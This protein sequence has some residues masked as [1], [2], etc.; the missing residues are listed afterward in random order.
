MTESLPLPTVS[1]NIATLQHHEKN[2]LLKDYLDTINYIFTYYFETENGSY[3]FYDVENDSFKFKSSDDFKREVIVKLEKETDIYK[4]V[5]KN[6]KIFSVV[7]RIG[8]PRIYK[9]NDKYYLNESGSFLH[10][11]YKKYEDY[12]E[13]IKRKVNKIFEMIRDISCN[14]DEKV[15]KALL[16]W[17]AQIARGR[18]TECFITCICNVQGIGKSTL[19]EFFMNWVFGMK[20]CLLYPKKEAI[21]SNF[22][23]IF[24]GKLLILLEDLPEMSDNEYRTFSSTMKTLVT[25]K[26]S[27]YRDVFEKPIQAENISNFV[28][29]SNYPLKDTGRRI[30]S[31]DVS[32]KKRLDFTYFQKLRAECFN[33]KVGEAVFSYLLTKISDEECDTF[34]GQRDFPET[35]N[36]RTSIA[37]SLSSAHKYIKFNYVLRKRGISIIKRIDL[38]E[39]YKSFCRTKSLN[40]CGRNGFYKKLYETE[41]EPYSSN[42]YEYYKA[43][44]EKLKN[45]ADKYNWI[46]K[47]DDIEEEEQEEN[48]EENQ[49]EHQED[50][51]TEIN[52]LKNDLE[53]SRVEIAALRKE[54]D[55]HKK[56]RFFKVNVKKNDAKIRQ[57]PTTLQETIEIPENTSTE[58]DLIELL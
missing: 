27:I 12:P 6:N 2:G 48:Q 31:L 1:F 41:I 17:F 33:M 42:G 40:A 35:E 9:Q 45:I 18:K 56:K 30:I 52:I 51:E 58:V 19:F 34:Y 55:E 15:F 25:E 22:N 21:F 50:R 39:N 20:V 3:Y 16:L 46:C 54:L 28:A 4:K 36:K 47:Y 14:E 43:S 37:D 57:E 10:Q 29:T 32:L 38:Y 23:K 26:Q 8:K 24:L 53:Q 5:K 13:E 49:E 7:C 44:Y 11:T